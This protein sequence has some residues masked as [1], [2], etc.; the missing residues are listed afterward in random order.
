M[1]IP[2]PQ[3]WEPLGTF[4]CR[5]PLE[6]RVSA[7]NEAQP[8]A[9][10]RLGVLS[11]SILVLV[12]AGLFLPS[13][14]SSPSNVLWRSRHQTVVDH[15]D[16]GR[17]RW[18][19]AQGRWS[20]ALAELVGATEADPE[21]ATAWALT[22]LVHNTRGRSPVARRA[23]DRAG[24]RGAAGEFETIFR[25]YLAYRLGTAAVGSGPDDGGNLEAFLEA[26]ARGS[27]P[28]ASYY[29][30]LA[31]VRSGQEDLTARAFVRFLDVVPPRRRGG[32]AYA[33]ARRRLA[34]LVRE[35]LESPDG[36]SPGWVSLQVAARQRMA[37]GAA[38]A[39]VHD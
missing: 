27:I 36:S 39:D 31:H 2:A 18:F 24:A 23:L 22:A 11:R 1:T 3:A 9:G 30:G 26:E 12:V 19:S 16:P 7:K 37:R 29:L 38:H 34:L 35:P 10:G 21:N 25:P 20:D 33:D 15:P 28:L 17:T 32:A 8:K 5:R 6:D 14:C 13:T 4:F